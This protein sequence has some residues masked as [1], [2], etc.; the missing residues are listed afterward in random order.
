MKNKALQL[1]SL[2]PIRILMEQFLKKSTQAMKICNG[3]TVYP[4]LCPLLMTL[5]QQCFIVW[6]NSLNIALTKFT[7]FSPIIVF[8]PTLVSVV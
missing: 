5:L 8:P 4:S 1:Y 6:L 2:I 3:V 7:I